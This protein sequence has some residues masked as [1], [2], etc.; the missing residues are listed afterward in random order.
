MLFD[1]KIYDRWK[2]PHFWA[3]NLAMDITLDARLGEHG[4]GQNFRLANS[5]DEIGSDHDDLFKKE[6]TAPRMTWPDIEILAKE[7]SR[8]GHIASPSRPSR[9]QCV[10]SRNSPA[11]RTFSSDSIATLVFLHPKAD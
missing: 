6:W 10:D 9:P 5:H 1:P 7:L 3:L 8:L 11:G 4:L 2:E